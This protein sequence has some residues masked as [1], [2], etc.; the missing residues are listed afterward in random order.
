MIIREEGPKRALLQAL[1]N[2]EASK[3]LASTTLKPKSVMDLIS[4]CGIPHTSAYRLVNEL[5]EQ[6]LLV[7]EKTMGRSICSTGAASG[8]LP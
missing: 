4:E 2:P 1:A 7:V 5:K 6:G 3:I 8:V